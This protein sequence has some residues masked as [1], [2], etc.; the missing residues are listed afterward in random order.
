M[1]LYKLHTINMPPTEKVQMVYD[2]YYPI[3]KDHYDDFNK[4]NKDL[5]IFLNISENYRSLDSLLA[6]MAIEPVIDSMIDMNETDKEDEF[7]T[8]STIHS[9][10]GLEWHS[11]FIIHAIDGYFPSVRSSEKIETL[12]EERRL[13]YVASTRAKQNLFVTYPMNMYDREAGTT[14]SKPSRF[15]SDI[16]PDKAEGWLV[17]DEF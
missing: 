16:S 7:V 5:E 4:R 15:I 8:L 9:A 17:E 1:L 11:V 3:F 6:D 2:Y 10:K 12:E 13:M 14:Y